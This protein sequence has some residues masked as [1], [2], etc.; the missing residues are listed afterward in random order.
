MRLRRG[1]TLSPGV[2]YSAQT[3]ASDTRAFEP[4]LGITWSPYTSGNTTLRASGGIFHGWLPT[5]TY[6]QTLRIDGTH[7]RELIVLN[8]SYPDPGTTGTV[9]P[10]NKYLLGNFGLQQNVRYSGGIDQT[11]SPRFR[12]SVLFNY[13]HQRQLPRGINLNP[14]V[15]GVRPDQVFANIIQVVTDAEIIRHELYVNANLNLAPGPPSRTRFNW[16][17]LTLAANYSYIR[18]KRNSIGPFDPPP[19]G[20]VDLEWGN[21]PADNPYRINLS[22]NSTQVRN[23]TVSVSLNASDGYPYNWTTGVDDNHDGIINDRPAGVGIWALRTTPQRTISTRW[24]YTL[25]PGSPAGAPPAS[26]RYRVSLFA[27][28]S[29]LTNHANLYGFSGNMKSPFFMKPTGAQNPRR[30]DVGMNV[31]F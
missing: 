17:R 1:L 19:T 3:H 26:V 27:S 21:G 9:T 15:N 14:P 2:R 5:Y 24:A 28:V 12:T 6:E 8:P 4:R 25:T 11:F 20:N 10:T 18:A 16:R 23:L 22:L 29:N 7:Q 30:V 31:S 13:F